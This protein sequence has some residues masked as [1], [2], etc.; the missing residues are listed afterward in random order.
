VI[1]FAVGCEQ[2]HMSAT[3]EFDLDRYLRNSRKVDLSDLGWQAI[4]EHHLSDGHI[5]NVAIN[6]A[7]QGL[8]PYAF[9]A[10]PPATCG[11]RRS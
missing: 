8:E 6:A 9:R 7:L 5:I 4:P 10:D 3:L 11:R 1:R 2:M